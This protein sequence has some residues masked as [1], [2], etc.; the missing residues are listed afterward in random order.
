MNVLITGSGGFVGKRLLA[1]KL[2]EINFTVVSLRKEDWKQQDFSLMDAVVHLAGK[3]HEMKPVADKVY[4]DVNYELTKSFFEK[5]AKDGIQHFIY[6]SSTKVYG[7]GEYD[8]LHEQSACNPSDAYGKSKWMAEQFLIQQNHPVVSIIRPPLIYGPGVKGN[9]K[10]IMELCNSNKLLPFANIHNKRSVVFVDNLIDLIE[11]VLRLQ[12]PG[13]FVAGD[14]QPV[15]TTALVATI[16]KAMH[17]KRNL[18]S[19]PFFLRGVIKKAKPALY[20]RLFGSFYVSNK[21]TNQQLNFTPKHSTENG[22]A[23]MVKTFLTQ[24]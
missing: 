3:A 12:K 14:I 18:F 1:T 21:V 22:I 20:T 24:P 4:F 23:A 5:V 19:I 15:S 6:I 13:V 16:R 10:K 9:M 2:P 11:T 17:K 7:D 8:N